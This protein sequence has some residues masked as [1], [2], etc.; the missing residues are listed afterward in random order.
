MKEQLT[1]GFSLVW[2]WM[3]STEKF[4]KQEHLIDRYDSERYQ[5]LKINFE[6][7]LQKMRKLV[8]MAE[9]SASNVQLIIRELNTERNLR[10]KL[11]ENALRKNEV[12]NLAKNEQDISRHSA[13]SDF[14]PNSGLKSISKNK[15]KYE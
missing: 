14:N 12:C 8:N 9:V 10:R 15:G 7:N 5:G 4:E 11:N 3:D 6:R 2:S 1:E 13:K